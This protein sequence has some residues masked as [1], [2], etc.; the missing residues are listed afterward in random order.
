MSVLKSVIASGIG[1]G[2]YLAVTPGMGQ[3]A[4]GVGQKAVGQDHACAW[5]PL[6]RFPWKME[7][8]QTRKEELKKF[9]R[10]IGKD[11]AL[12]LVQVS[13]PGRPFW[14]RAKGHYMDGEELIRLL[15]SEREWNVESVPAA[16]VRKGDVVVDVG[17]H[18]GTFTDFALMNGASK[19]IMLEP[20]PANVECLRRNFEKEI[21]AGT[22]VLV[23]EGAWSKEDAIEFS[24]GVANSG[25]GSMVNHE[26]GAKKI[27]VPVRPIDAMMAHLGISRVDFI[28][29][30]IEGAE[31]EALK[32]AAKIIQASKPRMLLDANHRPDD[33][34]ALPKLIAGI[35]PGY[36]V[37]AG[38]CEQN[39][40]SGRFIPHTMYLE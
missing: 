23:P 24:A 28:K 21:A 9:V 18:I 35:K 15:L 3:W 34:T 17:A 25:T 4:L 39:T 27:R 6:L 8:F 20:D 36:A 32:G 7:S 10:V 38:E 11:E 33:F 19:V 31:T 40:E 12:G 5:A 16:R 29:M 30:D 22:V 26:G 2:V 13:S 1:L 14:V 37:A